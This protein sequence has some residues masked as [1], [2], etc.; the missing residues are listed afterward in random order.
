MS[1]NIP[2][3]FKNKTSVLLKKRTIIE[4]AGNRSNRIY[5]VVKGLLRS[6]HLDDKG[7]IHTFM[8]APAG[9]LVYNHDENWQW[10]GGAYKGFN[11]ASPGTV[12]D[13]GT[14][15][16]KETS[17]AKEAGVRYTDENLLVTFTGFHTYFNDLIV[18]NNSN[19]DSVPD[20][21]GNV[22]TK[23]LELLTRYEP[24]GIV[25]VGD[26]SLFAVY[27]FT[28]ANLDGAASATDSK[29]SLFAGGLDVSNV[30]YVPDYRLSFSFDYNY[31]TG[32]L[33]GFF[34]SGVSYAIN[35]IFGDEGINIYHT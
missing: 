13:D 22:I 18:I 25:P 32:L 2:S 28:N 11:I 33:L 24:T 12:R 10:F 17:L 1:H 23:G 26:L 3:I 29:A 7:K 30:P 15:V 14:P 6:Y 27:T 16:E 35:T 31:V 20:N 19:S 4:Y 21:A 9:G 34:G 5:Y 8:F